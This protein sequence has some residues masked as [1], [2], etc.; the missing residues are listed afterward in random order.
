MYKR[1]VLFTKTVRK[2]TGS[3][4]REELYALTSQYR[5]AVDS[6]VLNI[7]EGS[8]SGSKKEFAKFLSYSIRSG[9]ECGGCADIAVVQKYIDRKTYNEL[10][11][12]TN[13]IVSMLIGLQRSIG[14]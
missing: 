2:I 7:A 5:R 9:Y 6:I 12:E 14:K 8:G 3:F 4:P 1:A 11:Q 10:I 13:E